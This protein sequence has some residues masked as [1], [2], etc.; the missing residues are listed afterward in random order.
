MQAHVDW[1]LKILGTQ[2][3]KKKRP[4][5]PVFLD[6]LFVSYDYDFTNEKVKNIQQ[7]RFQIKNT[8]MNIQSIT[9]SQFAGLNDKRFY[10][11][12]GIVSMPLVILYLKS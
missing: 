1:V 7:N 3:T 10:F 8:E 2:V 4:V 12:D 5:P 11:Y 6:Y 9:K